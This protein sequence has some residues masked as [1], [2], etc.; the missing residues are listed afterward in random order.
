MKGR[1]IIR[2]Y[3]GASSKRH[4]TDN[5]T[6]IAARN[7]CFLNG[8]ALAVH[9]SRGPKDLDLIA[10]PWVE[11]CVGAEEIAKSIAFVAGL[12]IR[13]GPTQAASKPHGR[14]AWILIR[15]KDGRLIDLSVMPRATAPSTE[16]K[17]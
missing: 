12:S 7:A 5:D 13:T 4:R 10:C 8:Y 6:I 16:D 1:G 9:G 14:L 2:N 3:T 17:P 15:E 11:H